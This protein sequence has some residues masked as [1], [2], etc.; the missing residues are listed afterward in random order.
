MESDTERGRRRRR[1]SGS[2]SSGS[3]RL[4]RENNRR[5]G[6]A[7][8]AVMA[9]GAGAVGLIQTAALGRETP[10]Y[11]PVLFG[12]TETEAGNLGAVPTAASGPKMTLD[13]DGARYTLTFDTGGRLERV[14][15][16]QIA[17]TVQRCAAAYG[18]RI[19]TPEAD[20]QRLLGRPD[21]RREQ[22]GA[23]LLD[24]GASGMQLRLRDAAVVEIARSRAGGQSGLLWLALHRALP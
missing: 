15:C 19:G 2:S 5:F 20:L 9:C 1:R 3:G 17:D 23:V 4:Q 6:L 22:A 14:S 10:G 12:M 8:F 21:S 7:L 24:Y 18:V 11:G 13:R 16:S